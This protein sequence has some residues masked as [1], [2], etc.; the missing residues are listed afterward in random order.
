VPAMAVGLKTQTLG[1]EASVLPLSY[2]LTA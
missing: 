1:D 2:H